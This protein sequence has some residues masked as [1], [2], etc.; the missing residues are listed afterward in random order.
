MEYAMLQVYLPRTSQDALIRAVERH[1]A[2]D[3][4]VPCVRE[5]AE[6]CGGHR[7]GR[8][9]LGRV[10]RPCRPDGSFRPGRPGAGPDPAKPQERRRTGGGGVLVS[11]ERRMVRLYA[12]A[13]SG[14][15]C[16]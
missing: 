15:P 5:A 11:G 16:C 14:T 6:R 2:A 1:M 4:M 7:P 3:G 13:G 12:G 8:L 10:R 9:R